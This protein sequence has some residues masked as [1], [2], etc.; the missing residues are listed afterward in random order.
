MWITVKASA[1]SEAFL[2]SAPVTNLG[3]AG[4][5]Y[6]TEDSRPRA[7]LA[8]SRTSATRPVARVRYHR[9]V[10]ELTTRAIGGPAAGLPVTG[11]SGGSCGLGRPRVMRPARDGLDGPVVPDQAGGQAGLVQPGEGRL[12]ADDRRGAGGVGVDTAPGGHAHGPPAGPGGLAGGRVDD[13]MH[14]AA[15]HG[16]R[17]HRGAGGGQ[18]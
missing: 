18:P 1:S 17:A 11:W 16:P 9:G 5:W 4:R 3:Q 10:E 6:L 8:V 14:P 2:C 7:M 12:A 15:A 13:V